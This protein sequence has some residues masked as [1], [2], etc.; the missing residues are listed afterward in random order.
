MR[1]LDLS[2]AHSLYTSAAVRLGVAVDNMQ[3][4]SFDFE[5]LIDADELIFTVA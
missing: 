3:S 1:I 4:T 2:P 5:I